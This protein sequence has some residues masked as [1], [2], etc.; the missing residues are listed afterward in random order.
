MT[1]KEL[2]NYLQKLPQDTVI[3]VVYTACSDLSVLEERELVFYDKIDYEINAKQYSST[4]SLRTKRYV[5]RNGQIMEY[6][7]RT[8]D[9][10]ETPNFV[11]ILIFPGN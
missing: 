9:P 7:E 2:I 8:W 10:K 6:N 3:G 4:S 5:L 1:V 11:P